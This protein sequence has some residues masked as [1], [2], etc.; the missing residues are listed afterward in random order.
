AVHHRP[1][2]D[3]D[4]EGDGHPH[5]EAVSPGGVTHEGKVGRGRT[6]AHPIR[7]ARSPVAA[8]L[9]HRPDVLADGLRKRV[10]SS[11]RHGLRPLSGQGAAWRRNARIWTP[12]P[13]PTNTPITTPTGGPSCSAA[14]GNYRE[15][16]RKAAWAA[17]V[18]YAAA[19]QKANAV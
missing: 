15:G 5:V 17:G 1:Q 10:G 19:P 16:P 7:L 14:S 4:V 12:T 13:I 18:R 8:G 2:L 6:G 3:L 11:P 9:Q